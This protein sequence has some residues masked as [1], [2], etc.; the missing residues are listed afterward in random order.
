[1]QHAIIQVA[2]ALSN[3]Q[4]QKWF[5]FETAPDPELYSHPA[6]DNIIYDYDRIWFSS[7]SL[8]EDDGLIELYGEPPPADISTAPAANYLA[9]RRQALAEAVLADEG[10]KGL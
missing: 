10:C 1:M 5:D 9:D 8:G 2:C 4:D 3:I 7:A 6:R